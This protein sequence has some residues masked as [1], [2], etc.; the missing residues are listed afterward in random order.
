MAENLTAFLF[1]ANGAGWPEPGR[2]V[3]VS[4]GHVL[5]DEEG[6]VVALL[7]FEALGAARARC[8]VGLVGPGREAAGPDALDDQRYLR[9]AAA[10]FGLWFARPGAAPAAALHR[11]R[12]AAPG[13]VLASPAAGAAGAGALGMLAIGAT[14]L[15]CAAALSG[16]PLAR[17]RPRVVGV[18]L[19]GA[20][21]GGTGGAEALDRLAG[22]LGREARGAVLEY[23]GE[24]LASL[25]MAE[26]IA[27][28]SLA[29]RRL[30]ALASVFPCD[31]AVRDYLAARGREGDWRRFVG[32]R[33]RFDH[34]VEL[35]LSAVAAL[36]SSRGLAVTVARVGALAEDDDLRAL[37]DALGHV[38][39]PAET[40]IEVVSGGRAAR[41]ALSADGTLERLQRAGVKVLDAGDPEAAVPLPEGALACHDEEALDGGAIA[42][43]APALAARLAKL[44]APTARTVAAPES[45]ALDPSE[46][47]G[48]RE[49][50]GP[51][52]RGAAHRVPSPLPPLE[53]GL[54]GEVLVR[55]SGRV[56]C[57][58]VLPWG[59]RSRAL[60]GDARA[61]AENWGRGLDPAAA[62]RGFARG[63]GFIATDG[64]YGLGEPSEAAARATAALGVRAV[65]A[66][67]FE[68]AHAR[69]LI[70]CGILPLRWTRAGDAQNVSA[71]DELEL[72][73]LSEVLSAGPRVT[74][75]HLTRGLSFRVEHELDAWSLE[76]VRTGGLL[77]YALEPERT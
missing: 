5:L 38:V 37:A 76:L 33:E 40:R 51:V 9:T 72:P 27:M 3:R 53:S 69:A 50:P 34:T 52:E 47:L 28:A 77:G 44:A 35:D 46:L 45:A 64:E 14:P 42:V 48:P 31:D 61:L 58:D 6:G 41:A 18:R 49:S 54:R 71:G 68:P 66:A 17:P 30:G 16:R 57:S 74:V 11:R 1:E 32:D 75:R 24:G 36:T 13:D 56:A 15:E 73:M 29:P 12:F 7:A 63:G 70:L 19:S 21:P 23:F 55:A 25:P 2:P 10:A 20:L 22:S 39:L 65:F 43:S 67:A 60:R 62:A 26:R 4:P 59:P 8:A